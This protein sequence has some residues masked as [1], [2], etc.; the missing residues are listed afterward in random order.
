MSNNEDL[1]TLDDFSDSQAGGFGL[2]EP[3]SIRGTIKVGKVEYAIDLQWETP[4]DAGKAAKEAREYAAAA[5][6]DDR[7]DFFCVRKGSKTQ[8]GLGFAKL[9]HKTNL[10]SLAAHIC[11]SKKPNF[12]ALFKIDGGFYLLAVRDDNIL[13]DT[14][15]FIE[16][17]GEASNALNRLINQYDYPE[18][19]APQQFDIDGSKEQ[20]I[21]EVLSG[22]TSVR[23]KEIKRSSSY[24]K[25]ALAGGVAVAVIFGGRYYYQMV[26]QERID[27][28]AKLMFDQAQETVGLKEAKI[29]IPR[30]PW[31][32]QPMGVRLLETCLAEIQKFPLD[33]PG[34]NVT[35]L[36]C[37][38]GDGNANIA[39]FITREISLE[40]GG[41]PINGAIQM[42]KHNGLNP[43]LNVG[44]NGDSSG[45]FGFTWAVGGIPKIPADIQTEKKAVIVRSLLR[46]M[47]ARRTS[48]TFSPAEPSDYWEGI[49][50]EFKT[51][52]SP[53]SFA[54]V[55]GAVPGFMLDNL[56]YR[57][58]DNVYTIKGKAYEQKPLPENAVQ[59]R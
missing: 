29:E 27:E 35:S 4:N 21:E 11:Q 6:Q 59:Q 26:A 31:D 3:T 58:E 49:N 25:W 34:W 22:S 9:G 55:L 1:F 7:P 12:V 5:A 17:S 23:L 46:I 8:Y 50:I 33:I 56:E 16:N 43:M 32:G 41:M 42:V 47:E 28:A 24:V 15:R 57:V 54:D 48:V 53:L 40:D 2:S 14:E 44:G 37:A 19:I 20:S 51:S 10:P 39:A 45:P 18:I 38:S 36:D 13:S 52:L 30:M